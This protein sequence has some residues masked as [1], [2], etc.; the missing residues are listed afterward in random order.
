MWHVFVFHVFLSLSTIPLQWLYSISFVVS[1]VV[2]RWL[3]ST[4]LAIGNNVARPIHVQV[5]VWTNVFMSLG[6][7]PQSRIAK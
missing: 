6:Y 2:G 5:F 1:L 7:V 3:V 4:F